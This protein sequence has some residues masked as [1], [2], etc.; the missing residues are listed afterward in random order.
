MFDLHRVFNM[1]TV[2]LN[3]ERVHVRFHHKSLGSSAAVVNGREEHP[4]GIPTG[5]GCVIVQYPASYCDY[6]A[7]KL[8]LPMM[9]ITL[10]CIIT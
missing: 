10:A 9:I 7:T 1:A 5:V 4:G 8:M 6:Q 3:P 2:R